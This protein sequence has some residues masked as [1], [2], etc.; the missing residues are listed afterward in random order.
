MQAVPYLLGFHPRRSVV[1]VGLHDGSLV[2]TARLD[3]A[4]CVRTD[5]WGR[6]GAVTNTLATL[7]GSG[8]TEV[9]VVVAGDDEPAAAPPLPLW[10]LAE[11][12]EAAV[13]ESGCVPIEVVYLHGGRWWSYTCADAYCC[14]PD[15]SAVP[16]M[17]SAFLAEATFRG[18]VAL[19]DR[20][21][22]AAQ[23]DPLPAPERARLR[24]AVAAA[25]RDAARAEA[26]GAGDRHARAA[27]RALF[28]AARHSEEARAP[29]VDDDVAAGFGVA[30]ADRRVFEPLWLAVDAERLDGRPLWR[31]LARRLPAPLDARALFLHGWTCWRHGDGAQAGEAAQRAAASDPELHPADLLLGVLARGIDPRTFPRLRRPA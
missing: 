2:V 15:G 26:E 13:V 1:L 10:P 18:M 14:P 21:A 9:V 31:D 19:P 27:K 20:E 12:V 23:L 3:I 16:E 4:D 7:T 30:L 28:A 29:A 5:G 8:V 11:Q 25:E 17:P 22:M 24:F 6:A